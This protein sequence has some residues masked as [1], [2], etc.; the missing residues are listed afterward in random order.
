MLKKG[1]YFQLQQ[2][3]YYREHLTH[4]ENNE[5]YVMDFAMGGQNYEVLHFMWEHSTKSSV[6][7]IFKKDVTSMSISYLYVEGS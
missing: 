6:K 5:E 2:C 3:D 7:A 4:T 1:W